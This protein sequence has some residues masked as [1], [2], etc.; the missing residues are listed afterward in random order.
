MNIKTRRQ[1][2]KLWNKSNLKYLITVIC[3]LATVFLAFRIFFT[4]DKVISA[5]VIDYLPSENILV[6]DDNKK[7][8]E[9]RIRLTDQTKIYD[10]KKLSVSISS[11]QPGF[12]IKVTGHYQDNRKFYLAQNIQ[13]EEAPQII[14]TSIS[15]NDTLTENRIIYGSTNLRQDKIYFSLQ[16][17]RT[18]Q[19]L[20]KDAS[21][22]LGF[23]DGKEYADFFFQTKIDFI[24]ADIRQDD[25]LTLE[26]FQK[27]E[28]GKVISNIKL[29]LKLSIALSRDFR[30]YFAHG[31]DQ[32]KDCQNIRSVRYKDI[33]F[34]GRIVDFL[35]ENLVKGPPQE[36]QKENYFTNLNKNIKLN[37][38][39]N[40]SGIVTL[41]FN[42]KMS[43]LSES[44]AK[45]AAMQIIQTISEIP[46][47]K[48]VRIT[49]EG[50]EDSKFDVSR[51]LP[52]KELMTSPQ[53]RNR[54]RP[55]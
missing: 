50:E 1:L 7:N 29:P 13:V 4:S 17:R 14:I 21:F 48:A 55:E 2:R 11:L 43:E 37:E 28:K 32:D 41:D 30:I 52:Q 6:V 20:T 18:K 38:V 9:V 27:D 23:E 8:K 3:S 51:R 44:Q 19:Y 10:N 15:A 12:L 42:K 26:I 16:N 25:P 24:T 53:D 34:K 45:G 40:D 35:I 47:I 33:E 22:D 31:K 49:I 46:N 54:E 36:D 39:K 5:R